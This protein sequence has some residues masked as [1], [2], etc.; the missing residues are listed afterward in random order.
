MNKKYEVGV[1]I[2]EV[3][4]QQKI[5]V[6]TLNKVGLVDKVVDGV[7]FYRDDLMPTILEKCFGFQ[8]GDYT[9]EVVPMQRTRFTGEIVKN[10]KRYIGLERKDKSWMES[11][12][13][14]QE[15]KEIYKWGEPL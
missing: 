9:V 13:A 3:D 5:V 11:P 12:M 6:D 7:A 10:K 2:T 4:L 8:L 15:V 14:S 1:Y